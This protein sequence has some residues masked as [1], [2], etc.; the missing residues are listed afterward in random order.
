MTVSTSNQ[1]YVFLATVYG[2]MILGI[3]YD[4]SRAFRMIVKP[5]KWFVA[6][7]DLAFWAFATLLSFLMLYRVDSGELRLYTFIGLAL[8]WGLY[9]LTV[10]DMIV[11]FLIKVYKIL[12]YIIQWPIKTI[13]KVVKWLVKKLPKKDKGQNEE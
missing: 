11:K 13:I 1:A 10:R 4:I 9:T 7:L 2:G 8:G 12:S 3:V 5:G 6:I